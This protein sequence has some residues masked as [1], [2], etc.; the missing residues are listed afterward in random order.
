MALAATA[1]ALSLVPGW[2]HA[3]SAGHVAPAAHRCTCS[4]RQRLHQ[5]H[6]R[7]RRSRFT[8][9]AVSGRTSTFGWPLEGGWSGGITA[10]SG[11]CTY[12][13]EA[14]CGTTRRPCI[15]IRNDLTLDH[16]FLVTVWYHGRAHVARLLQCDYGPGIMWRSIDITGM[17]DEALGFSPWSYP[18]EAW[19]VARELR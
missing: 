14:H 1:V 10:D 19:G 16:W 12:R 7:H 9:Y 18:T 15:A 2:A 3:A 6:R 11:Y 17:G 13:G 5:L 8:G 4:S